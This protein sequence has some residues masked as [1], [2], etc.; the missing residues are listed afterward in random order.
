MNSGAGT[1]P[2]WSIGCTRR[3]R[4]QLSDN[5]WQVFGITTDVTDLKPGETGLRENE[6]RFRSYVEHAPLALLVADRT[7]RMV[8]CNPAAVRLLGHDR[9]QLL[10][11]SVAGLLAGGEPELV[12]RALAALTD[13]QP[14][15]GEFPLRSRAGK[16]VWV[17]LRAV[18]MADGRWSG[19]CQDIT[20]DKSAR[21][22]QTR[23][24]TAVEQAVEDILITDAAGKI[25][26]RES[27]I[28]ADHGLCAERGVGRPSAPAQERQT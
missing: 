22:M 27:G 17:W 11:R 10:G 12:R 9:E 15:E 20:E 28:R 8:D 3:G 6:A 5:R 2:A 7:G 1:K 4:R 26:L 13:Q 14:L 24:A 23:L 18:A 21:E 19:F 25:D 16:P